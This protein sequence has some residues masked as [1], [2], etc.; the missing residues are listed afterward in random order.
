M[1]LSLCLLLI[2][3]YGCQPSLDNQPRHNVYDRSDFY[4]DGKADRQPIPDT[5]TYHALENESK[6]SKTIVN[7]QLIERGRERFEIF[8]MVCH[9]IAGDGNG[10]VTKR[11]F[12]NPPSYHTDILREADDVFYLEIITNGI[13]R[14]TRLGDR[15]NQKDKLAIIAYIRVLQ[16][17]QHMPYKDL[18]NEDRKLLENQK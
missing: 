9:G 14:M 18:S 2:F 15:I 17:S 13:G 16:L 7:R 1:K 5:Y 11:G 10:I 6:V 3:S 4:K 12:A 8:C